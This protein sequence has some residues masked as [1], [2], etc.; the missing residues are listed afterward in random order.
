MGPRSQ[1]RQLYCICQL[2]A[3]LVA[4]LRR[5]DSYIDGPWVFLRKT[6]SHTTTGLREGEAREEE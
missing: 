6:F 1:S 5:I 4:H 2:Y 3:L